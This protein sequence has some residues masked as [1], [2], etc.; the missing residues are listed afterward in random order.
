MIVFD[1]LPLSYAGCRFGK[2]LPMESTSTPPPVGEQTFINDFLR[3]H[4]EDF[5]KRLRTLS[6]LVQHLAPVAGALHASLRVLRSSPLQRH[7]HLLR[8]VP[9]PTMQPWVAKL[10]AMVLDQL[11]VALDLP[12]WVP[13]ALASLRAPLDRFGLGIISL[14]QEAV[15][16]HIAG[17]L[18]LQTLDGNQ[19]L[20]NA[21]PD[22][23]QA[24][25][26]QYEAFTGTTVGRALDLS[27][28]EFTLGVAHAMSGLRES[29]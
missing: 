13:Q 22:A 9:W 28:D 15:L 11:S 27:E 17:T 18:A 3:E 7:H 14:T 5:Q 10:D 2:I 12:A 29:G 21:W 1:R 26:T 25:A 6:V 19:V 24:A 23:F 16:C 4:C 20:D 8:T